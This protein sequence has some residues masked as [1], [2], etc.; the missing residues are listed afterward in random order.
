MVKRRQLNIT[1][2]VYWL[3][4]KTF[5]TLNSN[6]LMSYRYP[7]CALSVLKL[8]DIMKSSRMKVSYSPLYSALLIFQKFSQEENSIQLLHTFEWFHI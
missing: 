4:F 7:D 6:T 1:F 3:Y 5:A 8:P 2:I